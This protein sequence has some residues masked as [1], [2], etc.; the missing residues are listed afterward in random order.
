MLAAYLLAALAAPA[1]DCPAELGRLAGQ[2]RGEGAEAVEGPYEV[3]PGDVRIH[4]VHAEDGG[5]RIV[6][7]RCEGGRV[8]SRSWTERGSGAEAAATPIESL[9]RGARWEQRRGE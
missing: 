5:H 2:A 4:A 3:A 1:D 6:E 9:L 7:H 8:V